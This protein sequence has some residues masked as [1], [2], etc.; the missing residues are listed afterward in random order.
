MKLKAI[1]ISAFFR[2]LRVFLSQLPAV[3]AYLVGLKPEWAITLSLIGT[4]GVAF[5]KFARDMKWW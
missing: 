5:D 2:F 1:Q 4:V 3:C